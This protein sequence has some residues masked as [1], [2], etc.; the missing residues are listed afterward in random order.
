M[1]HPFRQYLVTGLGMIRASVPERFSSPVVSTARWAKERARRW[2]DETGWLL[3]CNF[4]P[5]TA[6]NQ[7]EMWQADTWDAATIDRELGWAERL[8]MNSVRVFLHDLLWSCEGQ[9]F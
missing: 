4:V 7:L 1:P 2:Y 3:G 5:S 8:G 9:A 6:G